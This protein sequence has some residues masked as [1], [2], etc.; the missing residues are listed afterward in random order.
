MA[1]RCRGSTEGFPTKSSNLFVGNQFRKLNVASTKIL[2]IF[3][4][5]YDDYSSEWNFFFAVK[6]VVG[7]QP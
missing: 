5:C 1:A 2:A 3:L 7:Y 6:C 4:C